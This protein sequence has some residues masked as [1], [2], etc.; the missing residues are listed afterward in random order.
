MLYLFF[1]VVLTIYAISYFIYRFTEDAVANKVN[2]Y[3]TML[4]GSDVKIDKPVD[5]WG[6]IR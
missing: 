1:H 4:L 3:R 5:E 6:R 2:N